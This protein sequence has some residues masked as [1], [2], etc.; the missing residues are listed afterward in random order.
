M[1]GVNGNLTITADGD[2]PVKG[3]TMKLSSILVEGGLGGG[4]V[5]LQWRKLASTYIDVGTDTNFSAVGGTNF[6]IAA[7]DLNINV[8]GATTPTIEISIEEI[9]RT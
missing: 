3:Y 5:K 2:Y 6:A 9:R 8:A 1:A 4:T 7:T